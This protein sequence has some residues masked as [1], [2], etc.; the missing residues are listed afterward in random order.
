MAESR[1]IYLLGI[2]RNIHG[3]AALVKDGV[4][5]AAA[6]EERFTRRKQESRFPEHAIAYCREAGITMRD[7]S[8]A[9]FYWQP[10]KGLLKRL[11][12][13][14]RYFPESLQTFQRG[15]AWR[16]SVGTL[17]RHIAVPFRLRRMGFRGGFHFVDHHLAHA[18]SAFFVSPCSRRRFSPST[19]AAKAARPSSA[20]AAAARSR[21]SSG[22]I[23]RTRSA[24]STPA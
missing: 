7:V 12:W 14:V 9:G 10:W 3:S 24:S 15:R 21:R 11:Q 8:Y 23:F 13:V 5:I 4:L 6:E 18:A 20:A 16:E 1:G 19:C 2:S 17:M 22:S